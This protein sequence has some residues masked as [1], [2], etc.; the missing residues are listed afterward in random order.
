MNFLLLLGEERCEMHCT[1]FSFY[2]FDALSL[3]WEKKNKNVCVRLRKLRPKIE[4]QNLVN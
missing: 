2:Y 4:N 3:L 1:Y